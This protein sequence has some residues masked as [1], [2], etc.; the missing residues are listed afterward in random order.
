MTSAECPLTYEKELSGCIPKGWS[1]GRHI[2]GGMNGSI[3]E[4]IEE[5]GLPSM[6]WVVKQT[7]LFKSDTALHECYFQGFMARYGVAP[8]IR[9]ACILQKHELVMV[10][11][12]IDGDMQQRYTRKERLKI[13][14]IKMLMD[15]VKEMHAFGILHNDLHSRNFFY[16]GTRWYI[17]DFGAAH[18]T[19]DA[20][21]LRMEYDSFL[22]DLRTWTRIALGH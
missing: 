9:Q 1:L 18:F 17:G 3:S 13:E 8:A 2:A 6:Q 19:K 12:R 5:N 7:W 22:A 14:E 20:M 4:L 11:E 10:M 15:L 16:R 21:L